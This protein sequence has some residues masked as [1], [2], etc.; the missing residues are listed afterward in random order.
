MANDAIQLFNDYEIHSPGGKLTVTEYQL[1]LLT[2]LIVFD[3]INAKFLWKRLPKTLKGQDGNEILN[4]TWN[5]VKV[6]IDKEY[7][8]AFTL[9]EN[10]TKSLKADSEKNSSALKLTEVFH[11]LLREYHVLSDIKQ[12]YQNIEFSKAKSLLGFGSDTTDQ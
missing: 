12:A 4:E 3:T 2:H 7:Q 1:F 5:I 8:R 9:T 11:C 10:L 6:L